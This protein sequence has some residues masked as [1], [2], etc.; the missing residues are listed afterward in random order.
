MDHE[1]SD[2]RESDPGPSTRSTPSATPLIVKLPNYKQTKK[3]SGLKKT[4]KKA[5]A[6]A[7]KSIKK[8]KDE[9]KSLK[10]KAQNKKQTNR[11]NE[12]KSKQK[13]GREKFNS[14]KRD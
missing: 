7:R 4:K 14:T 6:R 5:L 8:M 13:F 2:R 9:I 11:K 12:N 10:K 3:G 1:L